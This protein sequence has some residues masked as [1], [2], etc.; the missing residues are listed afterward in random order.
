MRLLVI[1]MRQKRS[2][3]C[4]QRNNLPIDLLSEGDL[5]KLVDAGLVKAFAN[6]VGLWKLA[7]G[8]GAINLFEP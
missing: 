5:I 2:R 7:L 4:L 3:A 8:P 1:A 6:A